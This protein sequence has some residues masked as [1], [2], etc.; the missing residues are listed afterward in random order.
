MTEY[1]CQDMPVR[2][3]SESILSLSGSSVRRA[4]T[5]LAAL[6]DNNLL[7]TRKK[8]LILDNEE[9]IRTVLADELEK[10]GYSTHALESKV[11]GCDW[12][13]AHKP[14][15]IISDIN[16]PGMNGFEYLEWI[17]ANPATSNIRFIFLTGFADVKNAVE[18][19]K[20]GADDF[21]SKPCDLVDLFSTIRRI[22]C[23]K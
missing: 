22:L 3:G 18:S 16:S 6:S 15:L 20:M 12:A 4:L 2:I 7:L 1:D 13:V 10:E 11:E 23:D 21:V 9:A 14:D 17:K 19:K 5:D 8:I